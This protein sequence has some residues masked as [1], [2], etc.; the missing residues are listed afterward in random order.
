MKKG[1]SLL[2]ILM[3][4]TVLLVGC[5]NEKET[6]SPENGSAQKILTCTAHHAASGVYYDETYE[7]NINDGSASLKII[8]KIDLKK[9]EIDGD[10]DA[11]VQ[12]RTNAVKEECDSMSGCEF[13]SK[14]SKGE[15][16]ETITV[17]G[18]EIISEEVKGLTAEEIYNQQKARHES[19]EIG[20]VYTCK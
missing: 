12:Q 18:E 20:T 17:L 19:G 9:T 15:Y 14:Y 10:V 16:L 7:Y 1:L 2:G 5:G 4:S 11:W 3:L 6:Q 13:D 8:N